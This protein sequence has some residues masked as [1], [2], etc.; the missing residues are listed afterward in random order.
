MRV[1]AWTLIVILLMASGLTCVQCIRMSAPHSGEECI[2]ALNVCTSGPAS[3]VS[4]SAFDLTF[5]AHA[6]ASTLIA[7]TSTPHP[8]EADLLTFA[9]LSDDILRPPRA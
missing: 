5:T 1:V 6:T 8:V 3:N 2:C 4:G 9:V 7:P